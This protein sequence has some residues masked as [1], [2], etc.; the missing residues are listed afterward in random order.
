MASLRVERVSGDARR[1][2]PL[3]VFDFGSP[4]SWLVAERVIQ[5]LPA[6]AEWWPVLAAELPGGAPDA[7]A[8]EEIERRAAARGLLGPRWPAERSDTRR[9]MLAA[10][11]AKQIGK[12]V[13]FCL[14]AFRQAYAGGRDPGADETFLLAG[15]AAE[16]HPS[17]VLRSI[18]TRSVASALSSATAAAGEAGVAAL[19]ALVTPAGDVFSGDDGIEA[20]AAALA[21]PAA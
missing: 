8:R 3:F 17:A 15:A 16:M 13:G 2:Q 11:Y 4:E 9:A 10:T 18:E 14:A 12:T 1:A 7:L 19:P 21:A 6:L 20:A 5:D